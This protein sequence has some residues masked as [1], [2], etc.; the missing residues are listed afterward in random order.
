MVCLYSRW[1]IRIRFFLDV[2]PTQ[3]DEKAQEVP[4]RTLIVR[5]P[6]VEVSVVFPERSMVGIRGYDGLVVVPKSLSIRVIPL[7][8]ERVS[9][10]AAGGDTGESSPWGSGTIPPLSHLLMNGPFEDMVRLWA[11]KVMG[12]F[13]ERLKEHLD[14]KGHWD[15]AFPTDLGEDPLLP[16]NIVRTLLRVV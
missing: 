7:E 5:V 8:G 9:F 14:Y 11:Y 4:S 3:L 6:I 1:W 2:E 12:V 10:Y 15:K 16:T 13:S